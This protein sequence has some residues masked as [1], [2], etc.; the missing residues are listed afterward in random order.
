L[1]PSSFFSHSF[2]NF[3]ENFFKSQRI[4]VLAAIFGLEKCLRGFWALRRSWWT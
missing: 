4:I 3:S 1:L 2:S